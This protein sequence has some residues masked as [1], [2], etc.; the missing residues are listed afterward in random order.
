M[1][2]AVD[3]IEALRNK[4]QPHNPDDPDDPDDRDPSVILCDKQ[5]VVTN[6]SDPMSKPNKKQHNAI[7]FHRVQKA[8]AA[9]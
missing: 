6:T 3:L 7:A 9:G 4:L 5:L 8:V 2:I 1:R